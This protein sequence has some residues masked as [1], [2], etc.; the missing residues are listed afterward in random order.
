MPKDDKITPQDSAKASA[1]VAEAG[2]P[3]ASRTASEDAVVA[4]ETLEIAPLADGPAQ[5]GDDTV[6]ATEL[7]D[8]AESVAEDTTRQAT[9]D[10]ETVSDGVDAQ[11][12]KPNAPETAV[13]DAPDTPPDAAVSEPVA[14]ANPDTQTAAAVA[15]TPHAKRG[16]FFPMLL[17]G[18]LAGGIGY[19]AHVYQTGQQ[20]AVGGD[21]EGLRAELSE[22]RATMAQGS[23]LSAL[24]AQIAALE[25]EVVPEL[26]AME[27]AMDDLRAQIAA[28]PAPA[29][30][31]DLQAQVEALGAE[32][33]PVQDSLAALEAAYAPLP[34]Q[35]AALQA[36][37][38]DLRRLATE[39][40][41]QAEA[42]VDSAMA[43]AGLDRI[44][45]ALVTGAPF[46]DALTQ[47]MQAGL[48]VPASLQDAAGGV[49]TVEALQ[50]SYDPAARAAL[51]ASLQSAPADS[52]TEKLGNFFRAQIGARSLA[53]REGDDP[54]AITAR[55]GVAVA[56]GDL[57]AARDEL[58]SLPEAGR[59]AISD[60][61]GA[62][63]TRLNAAAALDALQAENTT[64]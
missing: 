57:A 8:Q 17:G 13:P 46:D 49:R 63:E 36:D 4:P 53:P 15:P 25:P 7:P 56:D 31:S 50:E 27:A 18:V 26:T 54:D 45:A 11:A 37:M 38:E 47:L 58:A 30:T 59:A 1:T 28:L 61:L 55:A 44:R 32:A 5:M 34:D 12:E 23:D 22:L 48:D 39:E 21:L 19:G 64:E 40:V 33:D 3:D 41:A 62:V 35:I 6:T 43:S 10:T 24:E 20:P 51:A 29:D 42:A 52:A 60:W 9:V 14:D 16:G 2:L